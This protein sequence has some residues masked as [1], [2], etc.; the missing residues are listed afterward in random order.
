M[1][2]NVIR[3]PDALG[4]WGRFILEKKEGE[5]GLFDLKL[6]AMKPLVD[7]ARVLALELGLHAT[8][9]TI[10]RFRAVAERNDGLRPICNKAG[11]AFEFILRLRAENGLR[12]K[13]NGRYVATG[14]MAPA[15]MKK[16]M[17]ALHVL[18]DVQTL[19]R[20]RYQLDS[21]GLS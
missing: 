12:R 11:E 14:A 2:K 19:V 13:D 9:N 5:T 7:A 17:D 4:F 20:V 6:R 21:L 3:T 18:R 10:D 16:L 8:T 15:E 1:A